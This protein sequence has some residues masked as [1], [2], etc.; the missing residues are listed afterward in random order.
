M[1]P[2]ASAESARAVAE[3]E[4]VLVGL[5]E[6]GRG[7]RLPA[8]SRRA[9]GSPRTPRGARSAPCP[10]CWPSFGRWDGSD[11][12][13]GAARGVG[14]GATAGTSGNDPVSGTLAAEEGN[15]RLQRK[16]SILAAVGQMRQLWARVQWEAEVRRQREDAEKKRTDLWLNRIM[17]QWERMKGYAWVQNKWREGLPAVVRGAVW[18]LASGNPLHLTEQL[19]QYYATRAQEALADGPSLESPREGQPGLRSR[20]WSPQSSLG[21]FELPPVMEGEEEG[22]GEVSG[23][24]RIGGGGGRWALD[25]HSAETTGRRLRGLPTGTRGGRA[26]LEDE[27]DLGSFSDAESSTNAAEEFVRSPAP[28]PRL[29]LEESRSFLLGQELRRMRRAASKEESVHLIEHDISRTLAHTGMFNEGTEL[30]RSLRVVLGAYAMARPDVGY[31]QGMNYLAG[32][33]LLYM[34]PEAAFMCLTNLLNRHFFLAF[35]SMDMEE[36]QQMFRLYDESL[37]AALPQLAAHLEQVG[38]LSEHYLLKWLFT[39][40]AKS[41]PLTQSAQVWDCFFLDGEIFLFR[42][43]IAVLK[44]LQ[45]RLLEADFE[46]AITLLQ[47]LPQDLDV[48]VL[49]CYARYVKVRDDI[50]ESMKKMQHT[51]CTPQYVPSVRSDSGPGRI[52]LPCSPLITS[53]ERYRACIGSAPKYPYGGVLPLVSSV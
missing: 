31:V 25:A 21:A 6:V 8:A 1:R 43:A 53:S 29:A 38:V 4:A 17:P 33:F 51:Y 5:L 26:G 50:V 52:T 15:W 16:R 22:E 47:N 24:S 36:L 41:L 30:N 11:R 2:P 40:F 18:T 32:M 12:A 3:R 10:A 49:F 14:A 39:M 27:D 20:S 44:V 34:E 23:R 13:R 35:F 42:M 28:G 45:P 48:E 7:W 46:A 9:P 19:F 37:R